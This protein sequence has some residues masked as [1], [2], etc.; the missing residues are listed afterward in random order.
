MKN[1]KAGFTLIELLVVVAIIGLLASVITVAT[2][3]A[4]IK[5]RDARRLSDIQQVK[6]GLD[7]YY[8]LGSGYPD[9]SAWTA[10]QASSG[11][12][13]CSSADALKVPQDPLNANNPAYVYVYTH[14]GNASSGCG[15]SVHSNFKVQFQTESE[16]SLGPAGTY[17]LSANGITST[18]PF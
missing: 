1:Y 11:T 4:R 18:D 7:I 10:A 9:S 17:W 5:S 8:N 3:N 2:G 15:G 6:S 13:G 16:T 12:L 14:G